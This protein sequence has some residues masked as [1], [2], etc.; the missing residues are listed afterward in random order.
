M[1]VA[2]DVGVGR[3]GWEAGVGIGE[4]GHQGMRDRLI[5]GEK[6]GA[7]FHADSAKG[8]VDQLVVLVDAVGVAQNLGGFLVL[9]Q[10]FEIQAVLALGG[11][12][13]GVDLHGAVIVFKAAVGIATI[14]EDA[15]QEAEIIAGVLLSSGLGDEVGLGAGGIVGGDDAGE[16]IECVVMH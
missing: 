6:A 5:G 8:A 9:G 10:L 2:G 1:V 13:F 7:G 16:A 12:I 14:S 15:T 3:G 4:R 11:E